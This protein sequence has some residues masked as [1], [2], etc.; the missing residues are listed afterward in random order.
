M[1]WNAEVRETTARPLTRE[2]ALISSSA[3]PSQKY[4]WSGSL[5]R[6]AKGSTA[7]A[8]QRVIG[9]VASAM[10]V[11]SARRSLSRSVTRWYRPPGLR[12]VAREMMRSRSADAPPIDGT[13]VFSSETRMTAGFGPSKGRFP[14]AIS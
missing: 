12:A 13:G 5:V 10:P 3:M 1:N 6:L 11:M 7:I 9:G 8:G 2:S 4:S 14:V